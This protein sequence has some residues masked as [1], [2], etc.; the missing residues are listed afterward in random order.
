M[1]ALSKAL[2]DVENFYEIK[3]AKNVNVEFNDISVVRFT[4]GDEKFVVIVVHTNNEKG[5]RK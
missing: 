2:Q 3:E 1:T 4:S 5:V